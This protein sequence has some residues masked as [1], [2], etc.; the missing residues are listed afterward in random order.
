MS[1]VSTTEPSERVCSPLLQDAHQKGVNLLLRL[2]LC[3][4]GDFDHAGLLLDHLAEQE[5][6]TPERLVEEALALAVPALDVQDVENL[7]CEGGI[8]GESAESGGRKMG[9]KCRRTAW[10]RVKVS[11]FLRVGIGVCFEVPESHVLL[12]VRFPH[13]HLAIEDH[14]AGRTR[15]R[16]S[17]PFRELKRCRSLLFDVLVDRVA[18]TRGERARRSVCSVQ[19]R[20]LCGFPV[21]QS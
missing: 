9:S 5:L 8:E 7:V 6:A 20:V 15:I 2:G 10:T 19:V 13:E 16:V 4:V 11:D 18:E 14:A 17:L 12:E 1:F 3:A 21:S